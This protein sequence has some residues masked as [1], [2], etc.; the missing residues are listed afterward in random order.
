MKLLVDQDTPRKAGEKQFQLEK[1]IEGS[2]FE[3]LLGVEILEADKGAAVLTLPY[4]VKLSNGGGVM[5]GGA[6]T[7]LADT[8][9]AMAIKS[10]VAE[11]TSFVTTELRMVFLAPILEGQVTARARVTGPEGRSYDGECELFDENG[12][13]CARMTSVFK[14]LR[15]E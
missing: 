13:L 1:W 9:V 7:A 4:T 6:M 8:A 10:L 11:G 5:H 12:S 3:S 14:L 15:P 2:P